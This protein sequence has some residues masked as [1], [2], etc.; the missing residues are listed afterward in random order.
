MWRRACGGGLALLLL[1]VLL[2]AAWPSDHE[3]H[4]DATHHEACPALHC[5]GPSHA[6][7]LSAA[8]GVLVQRTETVYNLAR[9]ETLV[10][11][12]LIGSPPFQPPRA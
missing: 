9:H 10:A 3:C 4:Q 2:A 6:S 8:D 11:D 1:G 5:C 12:L 7:L